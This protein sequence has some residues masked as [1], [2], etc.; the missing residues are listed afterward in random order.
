MRKDLVG[1]TP[2]SL[3]VTNETAKREREGKGERE[4]GRQGEDERELERER[5]GGMDL[6]KLALIDRW[7]LH[8]LQ[9]HA[10]VID[11]AHSVTD[12]SPKDLSLSNATRDLSTEPDLSSS[13]TLSPSSSSS[14]S[15][16][17]SPSSSSSSPS[18][19]P[20]SSSSL[21]LSPSSLSLSRGGFDLSRHTQT[22]RL[23]WIYEICD[24]YSEAIKER[25]ERERERE[26][27]TTERERERESVTTER[28]S[29]KDRE[30]GRDSLARRERERES[31]R[32]SYLSLL[33]VVDAAVRM[34]APVMPHLAEEIYQRLRHAGEKKLSL[35]IS[36]SLISIS[37][38]IYL[39]LSL[40]LSAWIFIYLCA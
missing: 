5:L 2:V 26:S 13:S 11:L 30:R 28:E 25:K 35:L 34:T 24:V 31:V 9:H 18:L 19:S 3:L 1:F 8:R 17:P 15:P 40:S 27:V 39:S 32:E 38:S 16:S 10:K 12:L 21:S 23:F 36:L 4:G 14:S 37:L 20:S 7:I 6:S 29:V 22:L 33:T